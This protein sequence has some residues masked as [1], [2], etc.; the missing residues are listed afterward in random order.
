MN[1]KLTPPIVITDLA[2]QEIQSII[3]RKKVPEG[4]YLRI[5]VK[6]SGCA[7]VG[8]ILGFDEIKPTDLQYELDGFKLLVDRKDTMHLLGKKVDYLSNSETQGFVFLDE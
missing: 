1:L 4:Y 2:K 5:G 6:G 7:G 3:E 8:F